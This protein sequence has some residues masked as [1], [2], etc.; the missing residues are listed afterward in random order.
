M[1]DRL[2]SIEALKGT[3]KF[4]K[5]PRSG[6]FKNFF[7]FYKTQSAY[8]PHQT[9][10]APDQTSKTGDRYTRLRSLES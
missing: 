9:T 8:C 2:L 1:L 4:L 7:G 3:K 6:T 10:I 5:V